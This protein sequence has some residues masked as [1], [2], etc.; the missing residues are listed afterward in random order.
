LKG[1]ENVDGNQTPKEKWYAPDEGVLPAPLPQEKIDEV[2]NSSEERK[3]TM[4]K[5]MREKKKK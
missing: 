5:M 2:K 3:E 1:V 4:R